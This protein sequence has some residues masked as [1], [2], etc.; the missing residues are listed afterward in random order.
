MSH[1]MS[2]TMSHTVNMNKLNSSDETIGWN[3]VP[4]MSMF[5]THP[6]E[7]HLRTERIV[8]HLDRSSWNFEVI[9]PSICPS[10]EP[11]TDVYY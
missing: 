1:T 10:D 4:G 2:Q 7:K 9:C 6:S 11:P 8:R 3:R 5:Y